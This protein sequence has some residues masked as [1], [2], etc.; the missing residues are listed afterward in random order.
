[1]TEIRRVPKPHLSEV[2][3]CVSLFIQ[4]TKFEAGFED[5]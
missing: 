4:T 5:L 2:G 1:M 3:E